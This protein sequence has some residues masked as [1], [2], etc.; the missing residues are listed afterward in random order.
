[1]F[2]YVTKHVFFYLAHGIIEYYENFSKSLLWR[3][4]DRG[5]HIGLLHQLEEDVDN[6]VFIFR[7]VATGWCVGVSHPSLL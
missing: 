7:G 3:N 4:E 6:G 5:L 1:M 2:C